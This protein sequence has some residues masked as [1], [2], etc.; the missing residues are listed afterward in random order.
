[1]TRFVLLIT[2]LGILSA[3]F[4]GRGGTSKYE[5]TKALLKTEPAELPRK[6]IKKRPVGRPP[7]NSTKVKD[8]L[9][10]WPAFGESVR[11]AGARSSRRST[12]KADVKPAGLKAEGRESPNP[13]QRSWISPPSTGDKWLDAMQNIPYS[14]Y[15]MTEDDTRLFSLFPPD[16]YVKFPHLDEGLELPEDYI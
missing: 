16:D 14:D 15:D 9:D 10:L 8:D 1:M 11:N 5:R 13:S 2:I 4:R 12:N 3:S 7:R 6:T